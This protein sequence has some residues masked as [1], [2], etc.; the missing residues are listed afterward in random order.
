MEQPGNPASRF[1]FER[2]RGGGRADVLEKERDAG[3]GGED[4]KNT[5]FQSPPPVFFSHFQCGACQT[6]FLT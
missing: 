2:K 3:G 1:S 6:F 4:F 5:F